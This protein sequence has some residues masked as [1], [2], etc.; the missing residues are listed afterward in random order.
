MK[1]R[2]VI[3]LALG[4]CIGLVAVK[5]GLDAIR[6][7]NAN[8]ASKQTITAVK[9]MQDI[10]IGAEIT[11]EMVQQVETV[12][13]EFIPAMERV[14]T[15]EEVV[16]RVAE[17][18]IPQ[19]AAVLKSMLSAEGTTPGLVGKIPAGF[20]A[21]SVKIDEVT[22]VAFQVK[23]GDWV[24]VG[25]VMDVNSGRTREKTTVAE[26]ILQRVQVAAVGRSITSSNPKEGAAKGTTA[27]SV[28]LFVREEDVPKVQL[29]NTRGA[30]TLA[31]RGDDKGLM[32]DT[33]SASIE[34]L[35]GSTQPAPK[36]EA[37]E[38]QESSSSMAKMLA[39]ALKAHSLAASITGGPSGEPAAPPPPPHEVLVYNG[40]SGLSGTQVE[41]YTFENFR[42]RKVLGVSGGPG[43]ASVL[44]TRTRSNATGY[45]Q[46]PAAGSPQEPAGP[47]AAAA[48]RASWLQEQAAQAQSDA[49][50]DSTYDELEK[51]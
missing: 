47:A 37:A 40:R 33:P 1:A 2:A 30:V 29:A 12:A 27:K 13:N 22:S 5:F 42:S 32:T 7:A 50:D 24:D 18:Y 49:E 36:P 34:Q 44:N 8:S 17:K 21:I 20:R 3:P 51:E 16:G 19:N 43:G 38:P 46:I 4:L 45:G 15:I 26:V 11:A 39:D 31:M 35:L 23:P 9:A 41:Q 6:S 25:V 28:T 10:D 14:A 48:L